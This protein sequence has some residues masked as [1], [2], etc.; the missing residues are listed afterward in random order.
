MEPIR[1]FIGSDIHNIKA[2]K[3]L[4]FSIERHASV[5]IECTVMSRFNGQAT[6]RNWQHTGKWATCFS[7]FRWAVPA[8]CHFAGRAIYL[9]SDQ[10]V[11]GDIKELH[12]SELNGKAMG[13][14]PKM[15]SSVAVFECERFK[16]WRQFQLADLK[17]HA[18]NTSE[19]YAW[20]KRQGAVE[21]LSQQ[22]N[23][24]DG[25]GYDPAVTK[26]VHYTR[27]DTQ[28]WHPAPHKFSY[29]EHPHRELAKLWHK[30]YEM[31]YEQ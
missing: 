1:I 22:W 4:I 21:F 31:S 18:A 19:Y 10:L 12:D 25:D 26:L 28:P 30:Y 9:D 23:C 29:K 11:L 14:T 27:L 17:A 13:T 2:E 8:A 6:W 5:P 3:S 7:C 15:S 20:L 16:D 24:L